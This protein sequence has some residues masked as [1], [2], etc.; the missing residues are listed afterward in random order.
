M[1]INTDKK[2]IKMFTYKVQSELNCYNADM[3]RTGETY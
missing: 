2:T 3:S 1:S